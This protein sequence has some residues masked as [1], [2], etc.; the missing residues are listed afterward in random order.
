M[1]AKNYQ[2]L[3]LQ[4]QRQ[5]AAAGIEAASVE[6]ELMLA[7][8]LH[9]RRPELFLYRQEAVDPAVEAA[10]EPLLCRRR[11]REPWQYI[12]GVAP[13]MNLMLEVTPDVLIPRPETELLVELVLESLPPQAD[14]LDIGTGS[15]A[16]A[17]SL[18]F[19]RPDLMVT[20]VDISPRALAVAERNRRNYAL[21]NVTLLES[22]LFSGVAGRRF[23][24]ITA[25][26]P[27]VSEA[28]YRQL[29]PEVRD[30]EPALALTAPEAGL[31]L[32]RQTIEQAPDYL[33]P[34]GLLILENGAGQGESVAALLRRSGSFHAIELHQD[35]NGF[36]RFAAGRKR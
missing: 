12:E 9:C 24:A 29:E 2:T 21:A 3:L 34:D 11:R 19:E 18:A 30:Y 16:I 13:F 14:V 28:E 32:I 31:A 1:T 8:V 33:Q 15:G 7:A 5:L 20:A 6:A 27:Y 35:Y 17:L 4:L 23:A 26:L 36:N 10:L 25:N 22:D